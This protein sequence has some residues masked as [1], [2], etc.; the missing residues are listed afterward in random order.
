L[1]FEDVAGAGE[2]IVSEDEWVGF[3]VA[4]GVGVTGAGM[5]EPQAKDCTAPSLNE[6]CNTGRWSP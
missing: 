1:A 6:A 2:V 3:C 4:E 5:L